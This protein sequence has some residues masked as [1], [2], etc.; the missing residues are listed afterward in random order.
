MGNGSSKT[1]GTE[2]AA[3]S[4]SIS[5]ANHSLFIRTQDKHMVHRESGAKLP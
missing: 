1:Q 4:N 5:I 3:S 2:L